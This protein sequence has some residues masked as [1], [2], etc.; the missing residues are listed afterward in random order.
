M[1]WIDRALP[2]LA[3]SFVVACA[4]PSPRE[5]ARS[6]KPEQPPAV[7]PAPRPAGLYA[8]DQALRDALSS[9]LEYLGTG[10]WPGVER[11]YACA[12]RN[13]RVLVV[14]AYCSITEPNAFRVDVYSP[15]H[16]RVRIYAETRGPLSTRSRQ[17]Y[18][19]FM[20]ESEPPPPPAAR[21]PPL[22]LALSF[23]QLRDYDEQRYR[24]YLP[25]CYAGTD[26]HR[27]REGCLGPLAARKAEWTGRNRDFL[28]HA[29]GDWYRLVRELRGVAMRHGKEPG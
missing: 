27:S 9:P 24:A 4:A 19:T 21:L 14:N 11:M 28:Q 2:G 20:A 10:A 22:A 12:L 15:T 16:G 29:N 5:R 18:F 7:S 8:P 13:Q 1:L 3:M 23:F 6:P 25:A 17:D 26:F